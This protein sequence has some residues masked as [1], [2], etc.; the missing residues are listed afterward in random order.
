M[1]LHWDLTNVENYKEACFTTAS[2]DGPGYKAG[3]RIMAPRTETLIMLMMVLGMNGITKDN[4]ME[5]WLRMKLYERMFGAMFRT[6]DGEDDPYT[7]K[8]I[9]DHIGLRVNVTQ[10]TRAKWLNR[11]VKNFE[12]HL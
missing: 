6:P 4:S 12:R 11:M 2:S 10:E 3:D 7:A 9:A 5:C 8:M 1:A